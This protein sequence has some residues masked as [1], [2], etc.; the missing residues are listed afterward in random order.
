MYQTAKGFLFPGFQPRA[1]GP[2]AAKVDPVCGPLL[3]LRI[4][5]KSI[6]YV[7]STDEKA[8]ANSLVQHE[9]IGAV[10]SWLVGVAN[11]KN[12]IDLTKESK[13]LQ[14]SNL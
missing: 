9:A 3:P 8:Y 4:N 6:L 13:T 2:I 1:P 14:T 12:D 7:T 10:A 11:F 5:T